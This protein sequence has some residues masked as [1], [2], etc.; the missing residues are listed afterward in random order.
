[1]ESDRRSQRYPSN[2]PLQLRCDTWNEFVETYA[3]DVCRGGM[4]IQSESPPEVLSSVE[5]RL[6]LPEGTEISLNARVVHVVSA[7]QAAARAGGTPGIGVEFVHIDAEQKRQIL[8]LVEFARTQG[9]HEDPNASFTRALLESSTSLPASAVGARLS[10][11]PDSA[12]TGASSPSPRRGQSQTTLPAV[13]PPSARLDHERAANQTASDDAHQNAEPSSSLDASRRIARAAS[14]ALGAQP[15]ARQVTS[16]VARSAPARAQSAALGA[17]PPARQATGPVT[18]AANARPQSAPLDSPAPGRTLSQPFTPASRALSQPLGAKPSRGLSQPLTATPPGRAQSQPLG[19][20]PSRALSQPLDGNP[21]RI[22][23]GP[24]DRS[25]ERAAS[26]PL[27]EA[28]APPSDHSAMAGSSPSGQ[29]LSASARP[30]D[31]NRLKLVLN[32]LAH[33]HYE[34]AARLAR[35]MLLDNPGDPQVLKWQAICFARMA[36]AR[37]D[38]TIAAEQYVKALQCDEN[39]REARDYVRAY[40]RDRKLNS[41]PFGRYFLKKK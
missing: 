41:L 8:Q 5:V 26:G 25:P 36:L 13:R 4:F 1:M 40:E 38:A 30:T 37:G 29:P 28:S 33:K 31:L 17:Q 24:L 3:S 32:S 9:E 18:G 7:E 21:G 11:L 12:L 22:A 27:T 14:A 23:S 15:P 39:N 10:A 35:D 34:D 16:P 2:R 6:Q 19:A 20:R